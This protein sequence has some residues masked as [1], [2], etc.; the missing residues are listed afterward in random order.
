MRVLVLGAS[1][2][3]GKLVVRQLLERHVQVRMLIRA[4]A[5]LSEEILG[6]PLVETVR[7]SITE[8]TDAE[9]R[10]LVQ[11]CDAIVSCLGHN[12]TFKGLFGKPR[13]LV[14]DTIRRIREALGQNTGG[15]VKLILMSTTAYT[16]ASI[17]EKNTVVERVVLALLKLLLP[18]HRDNVLAADYL[19]KRG[20]EGDETMEW[21]AVRPDTLIDEAGESPYEV[22]QSPVRSP[23][24]NA[25]TTS[26]INVSRFM[27]E[28]LMDEALWR[29]WKCKTPVL[30]NKA[31]T[32]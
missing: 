8:L 20:G 14:F 3:T 21:V 26:R 5:T 1:G 29:T 9:L 13:Y 11:N 23:I 2:A 16:N 15:K 17:G 10:A 28:L 24:F 19:V 25:G 31:S 30:Y 22:C 18:P 7:G 12:I 4:N 6:N 32:R 27:A